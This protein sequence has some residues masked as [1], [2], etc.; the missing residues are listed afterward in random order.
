M[1]AYALERIP[2]MKACIKRDICILLTLKLIALCA[3]WFFFVRHHEVVHGPQETSQHI[4]SY[5]TINGYTS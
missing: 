4:I 3:L 5:L 1:F 2:A